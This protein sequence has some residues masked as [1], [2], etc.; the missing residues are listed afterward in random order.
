MLGYNIERS[1]VLADLKR[2]G[3]LTYDWWEVFNEQVSRRQFIGVLWQ[4]LERWK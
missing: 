4:W 3:R 2:T 1:Y